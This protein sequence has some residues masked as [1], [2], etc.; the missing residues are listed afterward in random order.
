[1]SRL[2]GIAHFTFHDGRADDFR[3]L[4]QRCLEIVRERDPGTLRY[5]VYL[6]PDESGAVVVEEYVD[7]DALAAHTSNIGDELAAEILAT[8]E[9][10]GE[11]LGDLPE[12]MLAQMEG[13][14]V[15]PFAPFLTLD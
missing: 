5:D 4:S 1:M 6:A 11:L 10:Y 2:L 3:R 7:A 13:G 8:G 14:P 15:H 12:E 9:V